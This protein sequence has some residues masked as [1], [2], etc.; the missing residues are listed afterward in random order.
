MT[1]IVRAICYSYSVRAMLLQDQDFQ[2]K[3]PATDSMRRREL[4]LSAPHDPRLPLAALPAVSVFSRIYMIGS[5]RATTCI[6]STCRRD[7]FDMYLK[8][9]VSLLPE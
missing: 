8:P 9:C 2:E 1:V 5:A 6:I 7:V 4:E 3:H